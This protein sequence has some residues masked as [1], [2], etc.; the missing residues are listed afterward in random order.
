MPLGKAKMYHN[1]ISEN[2]NTEGATLKKLWT[3]D[4]LVYNDEVINS[5]THKSN[6]KAEN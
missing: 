5:N 2:V 3:A 1:R 4:E 6:T